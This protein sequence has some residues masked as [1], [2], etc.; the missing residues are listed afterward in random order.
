MVRKTAFLSRVLRTVGASRVLDAYWGA[1]RLT[2]LAYHRITDAHAADFPYYRPNVSATPGM[3]ARQMEYVRKRFNVIDLAALYAYVEEGKALPWRPLLVTFDDGYLDNYENAFPVLR[4]MGLPAVIFLMTSRMDTPSPPW[5]DECAY[6][7]YH[8][9]QECATLPMIGE[10]NLATKAERE[11]ALEIML[12]AMKGIREEEKLTALRELPQLLG[13]APP[14][15]DPPL[16]VSWDQVRELVAKGIACQPHTVTHPILTR[17]DPA[18]AH[19]Q[20]AESKQVIER[21]TDQRVTAFAYPNGTPA[22]YDQTTFAIL[23]DLGY[24]LA[25]TLSPGP[26]RLGE[27][28][29]RPLEIKRVFLSYKDTFDIFVMKVLGLPALVSRLDI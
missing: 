3:F 15:A 29:Q 25:F 20:L 21:E 28:K 16:F 9:Q 24:R 8:T 22:D 14:G 11:A 12:Q 18:E 19:R 5:W 17:I 13:V 27:V 2:V 1:S 26:M 23:R 6:Y 10:Q 4:S 7:F